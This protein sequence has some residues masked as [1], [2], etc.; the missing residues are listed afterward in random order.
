MMM[1]VRAVNLPG[2]ISICVVLCGCAAKAKVESPSGPDSALVLLGEQSAKGAITANDVQPL[3]LGTETYWHV[4]EDGQIESSMVLKREPTDRFGATIAVSDNE[5]RTQFLRTDEQGNV[6]MTAVI[7]EGDQA[8]S[9]FD[10]PLIIAFS[11]LAAKTP[12]TSQSN[13]RVVDL[14]NQKKQKEAGKATRT[15]T[16]V[17]DQR[18]RTPSGEFLTKRIEIHFVADLKFADADETTTLFIV[19]EKGEVAELGAETVTVFGAFGKTVRHTLV[20]D[21]APAIAATSRPEQ[22]PPPPPPV[23]VPVPARSPDAAPQH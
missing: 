5:G 6:L 14:K 2:L 4:G 1:C 23:P 8:I 18:V 10:P 15:M 21:Q 13:M 19:P 22:Q 9:L 20:L 16:Y 7:E 12:R 17:S 3:A 11:E